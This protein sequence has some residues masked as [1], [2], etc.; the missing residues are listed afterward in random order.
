[1]PAPAKASKRPCR[2]PDT[3]AE[4]RSLVYDTRSVNMAIGSSLLATPYA[5]KT[6]TMGFMAPWLLQLAG[7]QFCTSDRRVRN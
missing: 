2:P 1:M 4:M 3:E 7:Y 6:L 5:A